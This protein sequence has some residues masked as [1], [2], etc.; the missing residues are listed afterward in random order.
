M[1]VLSRR[2]DD[3]ITIGDN[4]VITIVRIAPNQVRVGIE[5]PPEVNIVRNELLL[6]HQEVGV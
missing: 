3:K 2:Q 6:N 1:L 5:A 4:I